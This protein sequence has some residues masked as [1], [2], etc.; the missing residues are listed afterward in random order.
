MTY[1]I[2]LLPEALS[3]IAFWRQSGQKGILRKID[4]LIGELIE[5]PRTGTGKPEQLKGER[6]GQ[7]SRR[8][9]KKNR[10]VYT[11]ED[12]IVTVEILAAKGHYD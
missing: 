11:I 3:D 4:K 8:I 5:H 7:W 6:A 10:L 12:N 9:D 1:T 2:K